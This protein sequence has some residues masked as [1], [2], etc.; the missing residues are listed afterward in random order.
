VGCS[1]VYALVCRGDVHEFAADCLRP[2]FVQVDSC[3]MVLWPLSS[4]L[5]SVFLTTHTHI[6]ALYELVNRCI[7]LITR[8]VCV[9]VFP[10]MCVCVSVSR[11]GLPKPDQARKSVYKNAHFGGGGGDKSLRPRRS[12]LNPQTQHETETCGMLLAIGSPG[13]TDRRE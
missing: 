11:A 6:H 9:F 13:M 8:C 7:P 4:S 3:F 12:L 1:F 2:A 10:M 5:L